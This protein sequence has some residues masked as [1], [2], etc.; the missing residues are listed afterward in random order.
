M[1]FLS[2]LEL[3]TS[4]HFLTQFDLSGLSESFFFL[5]TIYSPHYSAS[6]RLCV[7][8]WGV[9]YM[10]QIVENT[11]LGPPAQ[12]QEK[13]RQ[14]TFICSPP[15]S[16]WVC[17]C[18]CMCVFVVCLWAVKE[19]DMSPWALQHREE[20]TFF[21]SSCITDTVTSPNLVLDIQLS[22]YLSK[23]LNFVSSVPQIKPF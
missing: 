13:C 4:A 11:P 21:F 8:V 22:Q 15:N 18:E 1:S 19:A 5:F 12:C 7:I 23:S 3:L 16:C 2:W 6:A 10:Y 17:V 9:L 14:D 20:T